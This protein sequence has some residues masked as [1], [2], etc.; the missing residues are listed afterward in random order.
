MVGL[1]PLDEIDLDLAEGDGATRRQ[2]AVEARPWSVV[3][4]RR[5]GRVTPGCALRR[6]ADAGRVAGPG[7]RAQHRHL[8]EMRRRARSGAYRSRRK[9]RRPQPAASEHPRPPGLVTRSGGRLGQVR[10]LVAD[11]EDLGEDRR[12]RER[13]GGGVVNDEAHGGVSIGEPVDEMEA[14]ERPVARKSLGHQPGRLI[15]ELALAPGWRQRRGRHMR[16][17]VDIAVGEDR[18]V[19]AE[20]CRAQPPAQRLDVR[21]ARLDVA[22]QVLAGER[23]TFGMRTEDGQAAIVAVHVARVGGEELRVERAQLAAGLG[24][25]RCHRL[26]R[27]L[28]GQRP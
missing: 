17:D 5:I 24:L 8:V 6:P 22:D 28:P 26:P 21:K 20:R 11:V 25:R 13:V 7:Q 23:P 2:P 1:E 18:V 19:E 16:G 9:R 15:G 12:H 14:P 4:G 3:E 27:S 10:R